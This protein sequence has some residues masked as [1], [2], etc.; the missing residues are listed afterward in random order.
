MIQA[1]GLSVLAKPGTP[2]RST[3][4]ETR[5]SSSP[6]RSVVRHLPRSS[7]FFAAM[8]LSKNAGPAGHVR[9]CT[10]EFFAESPGGERQSGPRRALRLP[11]RHGSRP[12]RR[13]RLSLLPEPRVFVQEL[14]EHLFGDWHCGVPLTPPG[15]RA[16]R[17][18]GSGRASRAA[19]SGPAPRGARDTG[20]RPPAPSRR[21]SPSRTA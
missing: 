11:G 3:A 6:A 10:V 17:G 9:H 14:P 20:S 21:H 13:V 5:P 19:R 7:W 18:R 1:P 8:G 15:R 2:S 4:R 16:R 12:R